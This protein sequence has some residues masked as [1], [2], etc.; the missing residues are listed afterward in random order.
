MQQQPGTLIEGKYEILGK[1]GEGG[2]GAIYK[3]RHRLLDEIRVVK[4]MRPQV[5]VDE[6]LKLRFAEEAKTATRL[7]HPN[8]GTI[9]DF[10]LDED[11]T[12]YLVMEF[13]DG[14]NLS[15]L[16][17][18]KGSPPVGLAL[19]IAHQAL[20]AL[21]YLHRGNVVHRDVAPDNL[22][23]TRDDEGRALVKV[24]DLGI[25]KT[26]DRPVEVTSTGV[27]LGKLKYA[28]PEQ[29]GALP[30]GQ[31]LDGRSDLYSMGLVLYE[32]L[33]GT[34]PFRG[35]TA[36]ELLKAHLFEPP[37][38]F[39]QTDPQGK[40]PPE[41]RAVILKALEKAR[42]DRFSSAEEFDQE[43]AALRHQF[44]PPAKLEPTV[45][46]QRIVTPGP[47]S[48]VMTVAPSATVT[49]S[50]QSRLN[51]QFV[52]K[53][54]TPYREE[55]HTAASMASGASAANVIESQRP[56]QLPSRKPAHRSALYAVAGGLLVL[57]AGL[58]LLKPWARPGIQRPVAAPVETPA[59]AISAAPGTS[60]QA[61]ATAA[62]QAPTAPPVPVS[63]EPAPAAEEESLR[64]ARQADEARARAGRARQNAERAGAPNL[65]VDLYDFGRAQE[66]EGQ[67]LVAQRNFAAAR[68]AFEAGAGAFG[69][70]E[71]SSRKAAERRPSPVE[72]IAASP[73]PTAR[74]QPAPPA[75]SVPSPA[76]EPARV[77]SSPPT[78]AA[79]AAPSDQDKIRQVLQDYER[80]QNT[81]DLNLYAQ[82]YPALSGEARRSIE[83]AW[84]GLKSQQLE[85]E[86]RN[87]ELK[88]SHAVVRA[89]QR[90][91]AV[92]RV[93]GEQH[94][95]RE[96]VFTLEKR[97][98]TWII[99][100]LS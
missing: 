21:G 100:S 4:V 47:V 38:P 36:A 93:G 27:F 82:V 23:L 68:A 81:L 89:Y 14:V 95:E 73:E 51:R 37:T 97:G 17:V 90:L 9:H 33:T 99:L 13:I 83:S 64:L 10:A 15:E 3:V 52:A 43:L 40:I 55:G 69:Q 62:P 53:A 22:M 44:P 78:A 79:H 31:R 39:S 94:D 63:E 56:P 42:E 16:L 35:N 85:L 6:E 71:I 45:S 76:P 8:I 50:A 49:P 80:A 20:L 48:Q 19:E 70:A 7:K 1:M 65:A 88:G 98:D 66:K 77:P 46:I 86:I 61:I 60:P 30:A 84:Q 25:A 58:A 28:S 41:L 12:A 32:L 74:P 2:M 75:V 96:R 11:G 54:S 26:M 34:R 18:L 92:P 57:A 29:Y 24:I 91:V 5:A 59:P 87:V 72:R 67:R